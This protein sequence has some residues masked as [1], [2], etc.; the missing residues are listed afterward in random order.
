MNILGK[1]SLAM[2]ALFFVLG[3]FNV[4]AAQEYIL[5]E[6]GTIPDAYLIN[7]RG[8]NESG[9]MVGHTL[10]TGQYKI[11]RYT[12][13]NG[14]EVL[15]VPPGHSTADAWDINNFGMIAGS[16]ANF[17]YYYSDDDGWVNLGSLGG[18]EGVAYAVNDSGQI[19]G[20]SNVGGSLTAHTFLYD[21]RDPQ[22]QITDLMPSI[23]YSQG[24][25]I[26]N[27]GQ[28]AGYMYT[29]SYRAFRWQDGQLEDLG[30]ISGMPHS[31][32]FAINDSGQVAAYA[33]SA[34]GNSTRIIRYTDGVGWEQLGGVGEDNIAWGINNRGD[35]VGR[36]SAAGEIAH[37][38]LY[39]DENGF[40]DLNDL[41]DPNSVWFLLYAFDIN[42]NRQIAV[43]GSNGSDD[44][45]VIRLTPATTSIET[46]VDLLPDVV[47]VGQNYPNPF[48]ARTTIGF[49]LNEEA[50]VEITVYDILGRSIETLVN[51]EMSAGE[52]KIVWNA[53]NQK[54]GVYFYRIK[55]GNFDKTLR[56]TLIK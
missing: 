40:Q 12:E 49:N 55:S 10:V 36:G 25:D 4:L 14:I 47:S 31:Y 8:I 9:D 1:L 19:T 46:G 24:R 13:G 37:A 5:E 20:Y 3:F 41:I 44:P 11:F 34:T 54:S 50:D 39:T 32:G 45:Q 17:P 7:S 42:D 53:E 48:N 23:G 52:H 27:S 35:V 18:A 33:S 28:I 29:S 16:G 51:K 26:N 2:T 30:T 21:I 6:L 15:G 43:I 38:F 22:P 56:M